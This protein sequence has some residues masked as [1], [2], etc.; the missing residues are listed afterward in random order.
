MLVISLPS[1]GQDTTATFTEWS[2]PEYIFDDSTRMLYDPVIFQMRNNGDTH[3][4]MGVL[5]TVISKPWYMRQFEELFRNKLGI[6][7]K[8]QHPL[9]IQKIG[10]GDIA[11]PPG[12]FHFGYPKGTV[13]AKGVLHLVWA[14]PGADFSPK[15]MNGDGIP[16]DD[17]PLK[18]IYYAALKD[19]SWTKPEIIYQADSIAFYPDASSKLSIHENGII[20]VAFYAQNDE[21]DE[22]LLYLKLENNKWYISESAEF[23]QK[24]ISLVHVRGN[25]IIAA[26]ISATGDSGASTN[27]V[28]TKTST[29]G[30]E[31]W[32]EPELVVPTYTRMAFDPHLLIGDD[33]LIYLFFKMNSRVGGN[34]QTIE[35]YRSLDEG[36]S[37][38]KEAS[39]N[40]HSG[41]L[42]KLKG[43][44]GHKGGIHMTFSSF[45]DVFYLYWNKSQGSQLEKIEEEKKYAAEPAIYA[46]NDGSIYL[47]YS[48]RN[49]RISEIPR[50]VY[51]VK[52]NKD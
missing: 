9:V 42:T 18:K 35:L 39:I 16:I 47:V 32:T 4:G 19:S 44:I 14:E 24:Y 5:G 17:P 12:T 26:Y 7:T 36:V 29:D 52:K 33:G 41:W 8:Q 28:Y 10:G 27:S 45:N 50:P 1:S 31:S 34:A 2:D 20:D 13:D 6:D 23:V 21:S 38:E 43:L 25:K 51:K 3:S 30:G 11:K 48:R 46:T 49:D 22:K 15:E 40:V 37:W